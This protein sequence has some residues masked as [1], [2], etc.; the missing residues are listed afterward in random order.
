M[1]LMKEYRFTVNM[2]KYLS[3]IF[4]LTIRIKFT[5][6]CDFILMSTKLN[7]HRDD[8]N[9]MRKLCASLRNFDEF[10]RR[11]F[12]LHMYKADENRILKIDFVWTHISTEYNAELDMCHI[13]RRAAEKMWISL[14]T[15]GFP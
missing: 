2:W 6:V 9:S 12:S 10:W 14:G 11:I 1:I 3:N 4:I 8:E 5:E 13:K 15:H 7:L